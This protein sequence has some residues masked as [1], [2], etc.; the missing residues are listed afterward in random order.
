MVVCAFESQDFRLL[1]DENPELLLKLRDLTINWVQEG[2]Q[3]FFRKLDDCFLVT[4][5]K[6]NTVCQDV[7]L[8]EEMLGERISAGLVLVLAQLTLFIE[9]SAIPRITEA[10]S[11]LHL[12]HPNNPNTVFESKCVYKF[13]LFDILVIFVGTSFPFL[14]WWKPRICSSRDLLHLSVVW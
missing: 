13:I 12:P 8:I 7:N 6:K 3:D 10:R 5:G 11:Q 9:Q 2:F 4:S 1:L 14:W